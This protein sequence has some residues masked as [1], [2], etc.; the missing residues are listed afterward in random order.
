MKLREYKKWVEVNL[1]GG[2]VILVRAISQN[3]TR[4]LERMKSDYAAANDI[5]AEDIPPIV[6]ED[7]G[8][9]ASLGETFGGWR[10]IEDESGTPI[11]GGTD[12]E[13]L[14]VDNAMLILSIEEIKD[15]WVLARNRLTLDG[16]EKW[17]EALKN[18][19]AP[20]PG[21]RG[22]APTTEVN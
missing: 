9:K 10:A 2:G 8:I 19:S 3:F 16:A 18:S 20:S 17:K 4:K 15:Q 12:P 6:V 14:D 22:G 5:K 7:L 21:G 11:P 13:S 1:D